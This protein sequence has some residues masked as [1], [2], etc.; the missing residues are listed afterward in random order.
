M[1][2]DADIAAAAAGLG[3]ARG[4]NRGNR[5]RKFEDDPNQCTIMVT[6]NK[7]TQTY[8]EFASDV[9]EEEALVPSSV[10]RIGIKYPKNKRKNYAPKR[11]DV[12]I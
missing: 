8:E 2:E 5:K 9:Q 7:E 6:I 10:C 12:N 11:R 3:A 1:A 4:R